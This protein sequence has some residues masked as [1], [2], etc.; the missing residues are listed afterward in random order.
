MMLIVMMVRVSLSHRCS[1]IYLFLD[2]IGL[3]NSED[4]IDSRLTHHSLAQAMQD[5]QSSDDWDSFLQ[6]AEHGMGGYLHDQHRGGG[7]SY[8]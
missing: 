2:D 3:D 8:G 5:A 1:E 7:R 4:L 6:R